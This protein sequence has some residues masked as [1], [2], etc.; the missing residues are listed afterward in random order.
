MENNEN[1]ALVCSSWYT[2][3]IRFKVDSMQH[4]LNPAWF[5]YLITVCWKTLD[6]R[7]HVA[8]RISYWKSPLICIVHSPGDYIWHV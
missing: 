5:Q 4:K 1:C 8:Y 7:E 2:A 3:S 6:L